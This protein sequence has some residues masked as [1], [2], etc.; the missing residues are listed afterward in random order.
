MT[1]IWND[2]CRAGIFLTPFLK[3][4]ALQTLGSAGG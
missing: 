1:V 4:D 2:S 3:I